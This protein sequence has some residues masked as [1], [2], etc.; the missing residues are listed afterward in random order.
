MNAPAKMVTR[1]A[2]NVSLDE[3]V[4]AAA[5]ALGINVSRACEDGLRAEVNRVRQE[6]WSDAEEFVSGLDLD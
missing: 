3:Q 6:R 5:K 4:V 1:R 2:T